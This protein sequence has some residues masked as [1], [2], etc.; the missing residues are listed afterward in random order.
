MPEISY[1]TSIQSPFART[2]PWPYLMAARKSESKV[3]LGR[4][5][6]KKGDGLFLSSIFL[7]H[8]IIM[9]IK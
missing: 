8:R 3:Y 5:L 4:Y 7:F 1:I 9:R 2:S 6:E